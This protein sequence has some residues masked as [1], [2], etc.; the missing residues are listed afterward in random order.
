[1]NMNFNHLCVNLFPVL[2]NVENALA[3]L[4]LKTKRKWLC[5]QDKISN[6][7]FQVFIELLEADT[8]WESLAARREKQAHT[9]L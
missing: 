7:L 6:Y 4:T 1:M 2:E 3:C 8:G 5:F 9:V